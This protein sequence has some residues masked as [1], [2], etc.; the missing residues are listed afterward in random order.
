MN[1]CNNCNVNI[2]GTEKKCPL[3][4]NEINSDDNATDNAI[5]YPL[6]EDILKNRSPLRNLPLFV[7]ITAMLICIYINIFTHRDG[8]ILWSVI[9]TAALIFTNVELWVV[10]TTTKRFG[11]KILLSYIFVSLL[12]F[13]LDYTTGMLFWSTNYVFPFLTLSTTV[14]LTVLAMRSKRLFS[15]YFGYIMAVIAMSLIPIP[16]FL[17]GFYTEVWGMFV[18]VITGVIITI[19]LFLFADKALKKEIAKRFH[20]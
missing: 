5:R 16:I 8:R 10:K 11:A 7:S 6:Y 4:H 20:R 18:S 2:C 17:F 3:C 13:T 12:L 1:R 15:E 19:G 14:Y 9:V